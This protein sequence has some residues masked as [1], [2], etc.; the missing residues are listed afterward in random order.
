MVKSWAQIS[1]DYDLALISSV[2][3]RYLIAL[4]HA[5]GRLAAILQDAGIDLRG[6]T[7][8]GSERNPHFLPRVRKVGRSVSRQQIG[9][10]SS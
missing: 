9:C 7:L 10:Q 1:K 3:F 5:E 2:G 6:A 4:A 8:P